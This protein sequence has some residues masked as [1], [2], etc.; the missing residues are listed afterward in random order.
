[1]DIRTAMAETAKNTSLREGIGLGNHYSTHRLLTRNPST[2]GK[3]TIRDVFHPDAVGTVE[4]LAG[5]AEGVLDR[6]TPGA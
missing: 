5:P 4:R 2:K 3:G 1:M 6:G